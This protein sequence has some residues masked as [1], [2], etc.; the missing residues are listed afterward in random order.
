MRLHPFRTVVMFMIA[1]LIGV[2]G[3]PTAANA[4][5]PNPGYLNSPEVLS[6]D[7]TWFHSDLPHAFAVGDCI[8]T[9]S[10]MTLGQPDASWHTTL[11]W[12]FE[13]L[14]TT[15]T[16]SADIWHMSFILLDRFGGA[17]LTL[18][19]F[20]GPKMHTNEGWS[21]FKVYNLAIDPDYWPALMYGTVKW[22]GAC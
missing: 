16:N 20:D 3:V 6:A 14:R 4:S 18:G 8:L 10:Y 15:H 2:L 17:I 7:G 21:D 22:K 9:Q 5:A 12:N 19:P 11:E 1:T 13:N